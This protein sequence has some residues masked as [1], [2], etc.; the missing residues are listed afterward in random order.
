MRLSR[1]AAEI[2]KRRPFESPEEE[3]YLNLWRTFA[4]LTEEFDRLFRSNGLCATHYNI[5]RILAGEHEACGDG[6]PVLEVRDRLITRV[7]DIT[8]LVDKLVERGL[9]KRVRTESDRRLILLSITPEGET[10]VRDLRQ[11]VL[12]LHKRQ[13]AHLGRDA[14]AELS[15]LLARAR[16]TTA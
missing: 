3:A 10:L 6:L 4:Q 15:A 2:K 11:P 8:R 12:D 13:L 7:P 16:A 14:L 9:V 1:L 5:L